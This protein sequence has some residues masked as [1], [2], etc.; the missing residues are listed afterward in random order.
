M[1]SPIYKNNPFSENQNQHFDFCEKSYVFHLD[2][3]TSMVVE[4]NDNSVSITFYDKTTRTKREIPY[5]FY[6]LSTC[7]KVVKPK[8]EDNSYELSSEKDYT[9]F[10]DKKEFILQQMKLWNIN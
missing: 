2:Y 7:G 3:T 1:Q 4:K 9:I 6:I 5:D 8:T 10:Y